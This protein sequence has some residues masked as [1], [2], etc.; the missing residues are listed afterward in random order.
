[1]R[2][3]VP[4]AKIGASIAAVTAIACAGV[5]CALP[6]A[7]TGSDAG[8]DAIAIPPASVGTPCI[9]SEE[10]SAT[11]S[12]FDVH[13]LTLDQ[14]NPACGAMVCLVNHFQ[15]R[16]SCPYGQAADG[17]GPPPASPCTVPGSDAGVTPKA[18]TF[19]GET[20]DPQCADRSGAKAV[21]CSCRCANAQGKTDDGATYCACPSGFACTQVVA[22]LVSGDPNAGG[23]CI[24]AGTAFDPNTSCANFCSPTRSACPDTDAGAY[25]VGPSS[26]TATYFTTVITG[27]EG[28]VLCASPV[29]TDATGQAQCQLYYMLAANDACAAHP[30]LTDADPLV[31]AYLRGPTAPSPPPPVCLVPQLPQP[32]SSSTQFGWC[33]V[34]G[35]NAPPGCSQSF[36]VSP[37]AK[38]PADASVAL[39]CP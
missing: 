8:S 2:A 14:G 6:H 17:K 31:A 38:P 23:Y 35:A 22:P 15:G 36:E 25:G 13:E 11:F 10:Y 5:G 30:G 27:I 32:C 21:Y 29:P 28:N 18:P 12:G 26:H 20:V 16:V 39:A 37:S 1:M 19:R 34:T 7:G 9:P 3:A 24:P 4:R 33:Y